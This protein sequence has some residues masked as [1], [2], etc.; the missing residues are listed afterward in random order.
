MNFNS[1][2]RSILFNLEPFG[3]HT[4]LIESMTSYIIRLSE[5]HSV[6]VGDLVNQLIIPGLE[7]EYLYRSTIY[8]G[9]SFFES[10]KTINGYTSNSL[11]I[12]QVLSNLTTRNDLNHLSLIGLED[13]F[14]IRGLLKNNL[15]WCPKC[16]NDG[17]TNN[18][19]IYYPLL[20]FIKPVKICGKHKCL[21]QEKCPNCQKINHVLRRKMLMGHC[22]HCFTMFN[23]A[24]KINDDICDA[25][26]KWFNFT[27]DNV[28]SLVEDKNLFA[29]KNMLNK[30]LIINHLNVLNEKYFNNELGTFS[31][32][33]GIPKNTLRAWLKGEN[34]PSLEGVLLICFKLNV[35]LSSL[36][37]EIQNTNNNLI[38]PEIRMKNSVSPP[39]NFTPLDFNLIEQKLNEILLLDIPISMTNAAEMIG[40]N[41]RVLYSNFPDLCK[42]ISGRNRKYEESKRIERNLIIKKQ[43]ENIVNCLLK[44][45]I[46]PTRVEIERELNKH[47]LLRNPELNAY[48]KELIDK[49]DT[50]N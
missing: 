15:S 35:P 10:S 46:R 11:E 16:I 44:A 19:E 41:K 45:G 42:N 20:W 18:N 32:Y 17:I 6:N 50:I 26:L 30:Q 38:L 24:I 40:R 13:I 1:N 5:K 47:S 21:L 39:R 31:N 48:W 33:V 12:E 4:G 37:T 22:S 3:M 8:G 28:L 23:E 49:L 7:K 25:D 2:S 43:I 14:T 9:N 29:I 27:Y 36:L 34:I